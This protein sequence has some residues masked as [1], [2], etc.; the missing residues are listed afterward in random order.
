MYIDYNKVYYTKK[1]YALKFLGLS[2]DSKSPFVIASY[3]Y[4]G[5]RYDKEISK[6]SLNNFLNNQKLYS[7]ISTHMISNIY[8]FT[9]I[10]NLESILEHGVLSKNKLI[11]KNIDFC[12]NDNIRNDGKLD[13]V[14]TSISYFNYKML[15]ELTCCNSRF[16]LLKINNEPL[17]SSTTLYSNKNAAASDAIINSDIESLFD[18]NRYY[19]DSSN[20]KHI[21]PVNYPTNPSSE[22]LIKDTID[23]KNIIDVSYLYDIDKHDKDKVKSLTRN[24]HIDSIERRNFPPRC[25]Y[26]K[27]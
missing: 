17:F 1:G 12:E 18:G 6:D 9:S 16:I 5:K 15:Y 7:F 8:H 13:Y 3:I 20:N 22:A 4:K 23:S 27:W 25:D 14:N 10:D 24:M 2:Y 21:L 26:K 11:D 19:F